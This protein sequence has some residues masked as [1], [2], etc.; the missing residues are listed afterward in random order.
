MV[1]RLSTAR[2]GRCCLSQ[3]SLLPG[4][5]CQRMDSNVPASQAL[6]DFA[7]STS[8]EFLNASFFFFIGHRNVSV[9]Y[10]PKFGIG[11]QALLSRA[12]LVAGFMRFSFGWLHVFLEYLEI[13]TIAFLSAPGRTA[14]EGDGRGVR[15]TQFLAWPEV[16]L[17]MYR[18][19]LPAGAIIPAPS[20]GAP[21]RHTHM[22]RASF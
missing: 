6:L 14:V 21:G 1:T 16:V 4:M 11:F 15:C 13:D 7:A 17:Q 20:R 3:G 18:M 19:M 5:C 9:L 8:V 12:F 2:F 10:I 22:Y